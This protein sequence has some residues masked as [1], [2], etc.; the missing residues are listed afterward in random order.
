MRRTATAL[1]LMGLLTSAAACR[2]EKRPAR[3]EEER[4]P[5]PPAAVGALRL[6]IEAEMKTLLYGVRDAEERAAE[7][8]GRY[9]DW[10]ELRRAY[11]PDPIPEHLDVRMPLSSAQ[12]YRIE[13]THR[14]T[15]IQCVLSMGTGTNTDGAARCG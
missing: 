8:R 15:G 9:L 7:E 10:P 6:G 4:A 11:Y 2:A 13:V 12:A 5:G 1:L 14:A 3:Q